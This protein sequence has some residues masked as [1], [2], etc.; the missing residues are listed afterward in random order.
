MSDEATRPP[1]KARSDTGTPTHA[2]IRARTRASVH[3]RTYASTGSDLVT[4]LYQHL[5]RKQRL[6][7]STY[8]FRPEELAEL[9]N[10][11]AQLVAAYPGKVSKNDLVR[12][13]VHWLLADYEDHGDESVLAL[14]LART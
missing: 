4:D 9:D 14:V 2:P 11:Y 1:R 6:A 7:S 10:V 13:G 5:Q 3:A 12:L 8:R